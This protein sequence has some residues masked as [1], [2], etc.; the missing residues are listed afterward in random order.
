MSLEIDPAMAGSE[1][2]TEKST[3]ELEL[4]HL[5]KSQSA[6]GEVLNRFLELTQDKMAVDACSVFL[7]EPDRETLVLAATRGLN[8]GK[9]GLV[10]LSTRE[11][12]IGMVA[13]TLTSFGTRE[14]NQHPLFKRF[15]GLEEEQYSSLLAVPVLDRGV[16]QG[17][18]AVHVKRPIDFSAQEIAFLEE[19][20][21]VCAPT[22][23]AARNLD[24]FVA[25][26]HRRLWD[27]ARNLWWSWD[28]ETANIF[29]EIEPTRW[30]ELSHNPI[31]LL[32]ELPPVLLEEKVND[33]VLH[34]RISHAH[35]RMR[36]YLERQDTWGN[37]HSG[38]LN[39]RPVAY[40]SAE[41]GLH[42]S[43]PIYSGGLGVLAGDH[44]KSASD[45]D[46]PLIGVGLF[47][48]HGYFRQRLDADGMQQEESVW[49]DRHFLPL[50]P[51]IG[52]DQ[53]QVCVTVET[54]Q[55]QIR[56]RV[57][58]VKVG[59][60]TLLLLDSDIDGNDAEDR[61]L[62]SKLYDGDSR[63]RIRQE[64]LL[65]VGGVR[66]LR[67]LGV[68]AGVLHL[69]EGHSAFAVL[70]KIRENMESEALGFDD[71]RRIVSAQTV[72]T[73][74]TPVPAGHDRFD[75][76]LME[77]H[78]GPLRDALGLDHHGLMALGRV[79]PEDQ[80]ETFC[81]TVLA[82][83]LADRSNAVSALH[84]DVSRAM[85][86]GLWPDRSQ[87]EVPIGHITNGIHVR[88]WLAPQMQQL[89][90]R[91]LGHRWHENLSFEEIWPRIQS[92]NDAELW[93]LHMT[94]KSRL[95]GFARRRAVAESAL[96]GENAE[97]CTAMQ[98][99]LSPDVLTIGFAR[100]FAT[101]KRAGL[102]FEDEDQLL[103]VVNDPR[104]P[105]QFVIAGKAHPHDQAGKEVIQKLFRLSRDPRFLGKIVLVEDY[106][107]NVG[108][109]FVQGVDVW[110]NNPRRP[111][112]ASGT[113]GQKVILNGG[114]NLSVLDGW[115]TE[116]YDGR[117]GFAI[118]TTSS[119]SDPHVQDQRDR[120][121][122][123]QVLKQQV[124]PCYYQRDP[125]GIPHQW[126][127]MMKRA[128]GTLGWRYASHRM[129]HDY[130]QYLYLGRV[131][132][133]TSRF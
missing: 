113:S 8:G 2:L 21:R 32:S 106:D 130:F 5:E 65:G 31:A 94:L 91:Y 67:A 122:L 101:Y 34:S 73:T 37:I 89:Y 52:Q 46:I 116:A 33:L 105:V 29:R 56:A 117:N 26:L 78:L 66:A 76:G 7:L 18:M 124:I 60:R 87:G 111:L 12:L 35:R 102:V 39:T 27:L 64:L 43:L 120:E 112:E 71:A 9:I 128:M 104:R 44:L 132:G 98:Q 4:A 1:R 69:N 48:D 85:W 96:R 107:I 59:R 83:K 129:V 11:G 15:A 49:V 88:S 68:K 109:H 51:A 118:G 63:N 42:E 74:H 23:H 133:E 19:I 99:S 84:G 90:D 75:A 54:R 77:E 55:S 119:H 61:T 115:W 108:R 40:F 86:N 50:T 103:E 110:L 82:L 14:A 81:M 3:L 47:Y 6:P 114:L 126:V 13:R 92:I 24:Q 72:F 123:Y 41:F 36:E 38:P 57:W 80:H 45:L 17:V 58:Q 62:T 20:A 22:I 125:D 30:R 121:S 10:R 131:G 25:P 95:L 28:A 70:E 79:H 53:Q 16:L 127:R 97:I 100:R 93:E